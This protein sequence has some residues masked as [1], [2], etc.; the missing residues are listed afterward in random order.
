MEVFKFLCYSEPV[1]ANP[2]QCPRSLM[3]RTGARGASDRSSILLEGINIFN[4]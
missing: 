4:S 3:D 2:Q 1:E